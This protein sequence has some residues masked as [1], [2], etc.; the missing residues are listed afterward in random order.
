M[1]FQ[2]QE[3]KI[4]GAIPSERIYHSSCSFS[5]IENEKMIMIFGGRS[6]E[7]NSHKD[8][9]TLIKESEDVWK[10]VKNEDAEMGRYQV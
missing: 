5:G 7:L 2:W 10:W 6:K 4:E 8:L 9:W 1:P 3:L